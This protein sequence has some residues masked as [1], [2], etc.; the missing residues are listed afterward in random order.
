MRP[1]VL[2]LVSCGAELA[3]LACTGTI[4][5]GLVAGTVEG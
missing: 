2:M 3:I 1:N 5:F 4:A